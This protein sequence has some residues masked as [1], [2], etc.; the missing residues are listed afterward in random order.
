MSEKATE[1]QKFQRKHGDTLSRLANGLVKYAKGAIVGSVVTAGLY[2]GAIQPA[3]FFTTSGHGAVVRANTAIRDDQPIGQLIVPPDTTGTADLLNDRS[4]TA[5]TMPKK[6]DVD[7]DPV[8]PTVD[9][10]QPHVLELDASNQVTFNLIN[11]RANEE[12][13]AINIIR[14][15]VDQGEGFSDDMIKGSA[16]ADAVIAA[17]DLARVAKNPGA[18]HYDDYVFRVAKDLP[19]TT[20]FTDIVETLNWK[21]ET[22]RTAIDLTTKMALAMRQEDNESA[23]ALFVELSNL[24]DN[25]EMATQVEKITEKLVDAL[26]SHV[27]DSLPDSS[28]PTLTVPGARDVSTGPLDRLRGHLGAASSA[29]SISMKL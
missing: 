11:R 9:Q 12:L 13:D 3:K 17:L 10:P 15:A 18:V 27:E 25:Y 6:L 19:K 5:S 7:L 4:P 20:T 16:K 1:L 2:S 24:M 22:V 28:D 14:K 21:R 8:T 29:S 23:D 26:E